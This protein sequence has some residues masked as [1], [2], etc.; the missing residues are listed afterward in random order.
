[1]IGIQ[2]PASTS[3]HTRIRIRGKG[4]RKVN[5]FGYGDHYV[6]L[7][8]KAPTS[9]TASQEA[10]IRAYAEL[11]LDTP[12]TVNGVVKPNDSASNN[13]GDDNP[14][15]DAKGGAGEILKKIKDAIFG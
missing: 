11:E 12:G 4:L 1:L 7:K 5:G 8:V 13:Q 3:S 6:H 9:L 15:H 14:T 2:I 10:L